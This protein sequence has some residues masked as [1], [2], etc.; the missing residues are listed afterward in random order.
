MQDQI[1]L[2]K[3]ISKLLYGLVKEKYVWIEMVFLLICIIILL[4]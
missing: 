1:F 4:I 2:N 3:I